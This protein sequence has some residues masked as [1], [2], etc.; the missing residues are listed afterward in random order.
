MKGRTLNIY[1]KRGLSVLATIAFVATV[2]V[3]C[4]EPDPPSE[5][6]VRIREHAGAN[7]N[8]MHVPDISDR[9][10]LKSAPFSV[11]VVVCDTGVN[12]TEWMTSHYGDIPF[13]RHVYPKFEPQTTG[14]NNHGTLC[15]NRIWSM[16]RTREATHKFIRSFH[17]CQLAN[18][19][20]EFGWDAPV[21]STQ[22]IRELSKEYD[23]VLVNNSWG[24]MVPDNEAQYKQFAA[25]FKPIADEYIKLLND[26]PNVVMFCAAGNE[27]PLGGYVSY[28]Y[29]GFL[30]FPWRQVNH[31]RLYYVASHSSMPGTPR[32][33]FRWS[34]FSSYDKLLAEGNGTCS[35]GERVTIYNSRGQGE[36]VSGTS[37]ASPT[38]LATF[39]EILMR[40]HEDK[41]DLLHDTLPVARLQFRNGMYTCHADWE[42]PCMLHG[43]SSSAM[44]Y[45]AISRRESPGPIMGSKW[46]RSSRLV[47]VPG[48][49]V[50]IN[51]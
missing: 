7:I 18:A 40:N 1:I 24:A 37:F 29:R 30:G 32:Y 8:H 44:W 46:L 19:D 51:E 26:C 5:D 13:A 14:L 28:K 25:A 23:L 49:T 2:W 22:V 9:G 41:E 36:V 4:Y 27:A 33:V 50:E 39:L 6:E 16:F 20:G 35:I 42:G 45:L 12:W 34:P 48:P 11:A 21:W 15:A 38:A 47:P 31:E 43:V 3:G 10:I 17:S